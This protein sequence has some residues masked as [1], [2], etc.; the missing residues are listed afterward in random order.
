MCF[1]RRIISRISGVV[2]TLLV[3]GFVVVVIE[4]PR[5][6]LKVELRHANSFTYISG[7]ASS[8][9]DCAFPRQLQ[10]AGRINLQ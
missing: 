4:V 10:L 7:R 2:R 5:E 1:W 8:S 6:E 9:D 3:A